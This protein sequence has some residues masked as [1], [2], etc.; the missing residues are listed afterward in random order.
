M[1]TTKPI[2]TQIDTT[3]RL[4]PSTW[5]R[6]IREVGIVRRWEAGLALIFYA[7]LQKWAGESSYPCFPA[8][9]DGHLE[10]LLSMLVKADHLIEEAGWYT[11]GEKFIR[12]PSEGA[13][14]G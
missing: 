14:G 10:P 9:P 12:S 5:R 3:L 11:L 1:N 7:N 2:P 6:V 4:S 13:G 8:F